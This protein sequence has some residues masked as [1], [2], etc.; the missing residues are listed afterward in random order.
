MVREREI[1]ALLEN[2]WQCKPVCNIGLTALKDRRAQDEG[3]RPRLRPRPALL[4]WLAQ[5]V[6]Q[7]DQ[8][9]HHPVI[10]GGELLDKQTHDKCLGSKQTVKAITL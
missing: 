5:G 3:E 8:A 10:L 9:A 7:A 4:D 2:Q 6:Q 1:S